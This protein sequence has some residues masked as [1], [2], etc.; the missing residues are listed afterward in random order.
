MGKKSETIY[1]GL[2]H[3]TCREIKFAEL[4]DTTKPDMVDEAISIL[5]NND[6]YHYTNL[7]PV[8]IESLHNYE[9]DQSVIFDLVDSTIYFTYYTH[10]AAWNRWLKYNY[11]THQVSQ[12]KEANPRLNDPLLIKLNEIYKDYET[13]DWRDSANVRSLMNSIIN[14]KIENYFTLDFLT[15]KYRDYYNLPSEALVYA[16]KLIDKYP[17]IATGYYNK[18][19]S[20]ELGNKY[21]EAIA[22]YLLAINCSINCDYFLAESYERLAILYNQ[23]NKKEAAINYATKALTIQNQYWIPDYLKS[24]IETLERIKNGIFQ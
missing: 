20:L 24:K 13:C 3:D 12:Y 15:Y 9:T 11:V 19:R 4:I 17:D 2:F 8:Y 7:I 1:S 5:S 6:F 14:S 10:Y 16:Q 22:A 21:D 23:L 18:G